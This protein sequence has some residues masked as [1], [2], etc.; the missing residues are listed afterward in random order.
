M[1]IWLSFFCACI[2]KRGLLRFAFDRGNGG[3]CASL[4]IGESSGR[5]G[6]GESLLARSHGQEDAG[7]EEGI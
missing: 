4:L 7:V 6:D 2:S 5:A 1:L 3:F